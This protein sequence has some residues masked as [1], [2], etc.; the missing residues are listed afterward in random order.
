[1]KHALTERTM[2]L[3]GLFQSA[4]Q[5]NQIA[6]IGNW[7][8]EI[9]ETSINSLFTPDAKD[10]ETVYG[11]ISGV[12][13]G[14]KLVK[15]VIGERLERADMMTT[16]YV[17]LLMN[18]EGKLRKRADILERISTGLKVINDEFSNNMPLDPAKISR[19]SELYEATISTLSSRIQ[20]QGNRLYLAQPDN[21]DRVRA[22]LFSGIRSTVLWRQCGG[23]RLG[24]FLGRRKLLNVI[25]TLL[26]A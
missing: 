17:I 20:V 19:I 3:S 18:L 12:R 9:A 16:R 22:M 25:D 23:T 4:H 1:M 8:N 10:I 6:T 11:G 13:R 15:K 14:L 26:Q 24:I 21:I 5:V 2:A 7:D